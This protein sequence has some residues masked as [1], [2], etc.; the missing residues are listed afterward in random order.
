MSFVLTGNTYRSDRK[1]GY[2]RNKEKK[3]TLKGEIAV[4]E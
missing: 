4:V 1:T 3:E 2:V